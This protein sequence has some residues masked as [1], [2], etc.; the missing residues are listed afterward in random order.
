VQIVTDTT[1]RGTGT[2]TAAA[3]G[4]SMESA[5]GAKVVDVIAVVM[6]THTN[7]LLVVITVL[8]VSLPLRSYKAFSCQGVNEYQS[9]QE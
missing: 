9:R 4:Y 3:E 1:T 5:V 7:T 2:V 6:D 8:V